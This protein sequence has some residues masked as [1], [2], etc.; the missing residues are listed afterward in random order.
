M[1]TR[2]GRY[3]KLARRAIAHWSDLLCEVDRLYLRKRPSRID[4]LTIADGVTFRGLPLIEISNGGRISIGRGTTI[5]SV[6]AGYHINMH[7][8]TKLFADRPGAVIRI[9]ENTRIHG[10]CIHA[11]RSVVIGDNCLIAANCQIIDCS[12]H[13][14]SF[15]NVENRIN[16]TS[17]GSPVV[18]EDC[19][20]IGANSIVLPGV[21]IGRGSVVAAGSVV[22]KDIPP[23]VVAAGNPA[24]VVKTAEQ[25]LGPTS[26]VVA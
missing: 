15:E 23:M 12:G 24:R 19:V 18:V 25:V 8:P 6:N 1:S 13:E 22:T 3:K 2:V 21:C 11:Y 20:W 9:G 5:N 10:T 4:G 26:D 14:L 17:D 16:T 7:S